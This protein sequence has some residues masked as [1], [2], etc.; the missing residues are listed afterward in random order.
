M[1]NDS[2]GYRCLLRQDYSR[3]E[4]LLQIIVQAPGSAD[5][6]ERIL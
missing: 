4:V 5:K 1:T 3:F 6:S 2:R